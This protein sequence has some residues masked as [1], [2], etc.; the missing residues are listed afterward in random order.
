VSK[1]EIYIRSACALSRQGLSS[2]K[3]PGTGPCGEGGER[4]QSTT[5]PEK[6]WA[7]GGNFL[8]GSVKVGSRLILKYHL[9]G[10]TKSDVMGSVLTRGPGGEPRDPNQRSLRVKKKTQKL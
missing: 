2:R 6:I 4:L 1:S 3:T 10:S 7:K 9:E 5:S 8:L